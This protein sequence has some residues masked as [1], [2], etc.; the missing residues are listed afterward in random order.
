MINLAQALIQ[1]SG[2]SVL[3]I[4]ADL[5]RPRAHAILGAKASPGLVEYLRGEVDD[6][7]I[8]QF[9]RIGQIDSLC[10][11]ASGTRVEN[12]SELLSNGRFETLLRR[13]IPVFDWILI[14]SPPCLPV[15][16]TN[17]LADLSDGVLIV[18]RAGSTPSASLQKAQQQ[19]QKKNVVG[20][21]LNAAQEKLGAYRTYY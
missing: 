6:T 8:I 18:A 15:A 13:L 20:M 4:D 2:L 16:D 5:R 7:D 10:F 11:I 9:G 1:K 14:D 3:V 12:P 17:I 19:L 21:V